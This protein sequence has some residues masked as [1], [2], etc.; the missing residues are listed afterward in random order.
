MY[1]SSFL[2][3]KSSVLRNVVSVEATIRFAGVSVAVI[4]SAEKH[5]TSYKS[6][7]RRNSRRTTDWYVQNMLIFQPG[8]DIRKIAVF[9]DKK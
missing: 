2:R 9:F 5:A 6:D 7:F 4:Y 1:V 3:I 8:F